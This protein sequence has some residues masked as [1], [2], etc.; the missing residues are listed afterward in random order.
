[1]PDDRN[2]LEK[3]PF[4]EGDLFSENKTP[5]YP[6]AKYSYQEKLD[7]GGYAYVREVLRR[8]RKHTWLILSLVI[9]VTTIVTIE[10]FRTKSVYRASTTILVDKSNSTIVRTGTTTIEGE[11]V[12]F[13]YFTSIVMKTSMR[14]LQS[15]P[16]LEDVVVQLNLDKDSH[17]L[18][19]TTKRSIIE[20]A[21][22]IFSRIKPGPAGALPAAVDNT[23]FNPSLDDP[24]RSAAERARLAPFVNVIAS[25]LEAEQVEDTRMMNVTF[26][27]SDPVLAAT[28]VTAV[29]KVFIEKSKTN[30]MGR[31]NSTTNWLDEQTR[32][33][34]AD[35]EAAELEQANFA[36]SNNMF[37]TGDSKENLTVEKLSNMYGLV[38]KTETERIL[39]GSL[40]D[41][42]KAGRVNS[43]P[44]SFADPKTAQLR[45]RLEELQLQQ[46]QYAGRLGPE[47]P[48][49]IDLNKQIV[50]VQ[51]QLEGSKS[52]L[53]ERLKADY[54]R[55]VR[56]E[57][58]LREAFEGVKGEAVDQ[59]SAII[60]YGMLKQAVEIS[61]SIYQDFLSRSSQLKLQ[62]VDQEER[63]SR[64]IEPAFVPVTPTGPNRIRTILI[65]MLAS[66]ILGIAIG[67]LIEFLDSS[68]KTVDDIAR[69]AA[70]PTLGV[71][72][73]IGGRK[74][75]RKSAKP[76][77][78]LPKLI[79]PLGGEDTPPATGRLKRAKGTSHTSLAEAYRGLRTSILLSAA[80][81]APRT[82]LFT[83]GQPSEGKTTTTINTAISLAQL[84]ASVLIID[85]DMRRPSTHRIFKV[86]SSPGLSTFL[87]RD[88]EL[89]TLVQ[90][91]SL[92][93][94]SLLTA[95]PP[96]PNPAEL[97]SS[98]RMK[99]LIRQAVEH[100]DHVLID[101]PPL[102]GVSD[103]LILSTLVDGVV[104][105][106]QSGRS[107]RS[108]VRRARIELQNVGAKIFGVVLNNVDWKREGYDDYYSTYKRYYSTEYTP[109]SE[110]EQASSSGD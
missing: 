15:R 22:T 38:L 24:E 74:A 7:E 80:G 82:M 70:L 42:V 25:H 50:A 48:R 37:T 87:S 71:I 35:V 18:E 105:V 19:V 104:L 55:S 85:A 49:V 86:Q 83:S 60:K 103:P 46:V 75:A 16:L 41:E 91:L 39:K 61:K 47:N 67:L 93:N 14:L 12:E 21:K 8:V 96:P 88:V 1:M 40:Y 31:Y 59:N 28:V 57:K 34:K 58:S 100:Y 65:G 81:H 33:L 108:I 78:G 13:P 17:F 9:I 77:R 76:G 94:L 36:A 23:P 64:I 101:S 66:L 98:V 63:M 99:E 20:S 10:S 73:M 95:G 29:A 45:S 106:V 4:S 92:P 43:L 26:D 107:S 72:P 84:G 102:L 109:D 56:E 11:D 90:E 5:H 6:D 52:T 110:G 2:Q 62:K 53:E 44:E 79:G 54:D 68:V 51:K 69:F 32:K 30:R 3:V 97:I 27:H 89:E